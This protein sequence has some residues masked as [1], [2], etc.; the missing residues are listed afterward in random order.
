[1]RN[2]RKCP[3][4]NALWGGPVW[5]SNVFLKSITYRPTLNKFRGGP[6]KKTP[7]TIDSFPGGAKIEDI[8]DGGNKLP[9][10]VK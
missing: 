8:S 2:K 10:E 6:V 9:K 3:P 4:S 5:D 1:M 7:C